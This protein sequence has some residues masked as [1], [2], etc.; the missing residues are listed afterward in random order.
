MV[1]PGRPEAYARHAGSRLEG[2]S[3]PSPAPFSLVRS[4]RATSQQALGNDEPLRPLL[5]QV[6][7]DTPYQNSPTNDLKAAADAAKAAADLAESELAH[8]SDRAAKAASKRSKASS[9]ESATSAMC[10]V[11][12]WPRSRPRFPVSSARS[13]S[14]RTSSSPLRLRLRS[15]GENF[16]RIVGARTS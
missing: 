4:V 14:C 1:L 13:R 3:T 15:N 2:P 7:R 11:Q 6:F 10:P 12:R 8:A 9:P 5:I 16:R